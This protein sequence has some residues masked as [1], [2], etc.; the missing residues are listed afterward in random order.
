MITPSRRGFLLECLAATGLAGRPQ[1]AQRP[2]VIVVMTDDQGYGDLSCHGNP[3]LKTPNIDA[4]HKDSVRL[5]NYHVSPTC[6]PTRSAL[7]TG[8]YTNA[9]GAWHTI[10]G[11]S[12]LRPDET[13][14]ADCFRA[15]GYRTGI[16]GKWHLG[17][18]Y[19][20]RPQERGFDEVLVHGG[21]GVSQTPDH[22]GND[23]FDDTYLHNGKL[24]KYRGFCT[25]VW[26]ENAMRFMSAEKQRGKPFFCYLPT[27]APHG[28]MWAP[29]EY[30]ARFR[31]VPGLREP[32][33]FGMIANIDDNFGRMMR[34]L[35]SRSLADNT[36]VIFT[37]DN[38]TASGA[39]VHNAGMRGQK[40]SPYEGG[41]RVPFFV[42][43]PQGGLSGG[44]DVPQLAAHVDVLPTLMDL[45]GLKR[46]GKK[47]LHGRSLQPLLRG[48]SQRW[49]DRA[50]T[51]DSQRMENLV[52]WRQAAVM[53][54]QWRLVSPGPG[55]EPK[56]ELYD[57]Q[58][59]PRQ[60]KDIAGQHPDVVL[61]LQGEYEKWWTEVSQRAGEVVRIVLGNDAENPVRLTAHDWHGADVEKV[62]HQSGIRRGPEAVG[63]WEVLVE[64]EGDYRFELRRW[65]KE[66][67]LAIRASYQDAEP[68]REK[69]PG[70]AIGAVQAKLRIGGV[71]ASVEV[72]AG[73]KAAV[74]A[75]RLKAGPAKLETWLL[76][77][78]GAAR[79]A[80]FVYVERQASRNKGRI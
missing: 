25:D 38:G 65:P 51:V 70:Q 21:G 55:G 66:V 36:I 76:D 9:T 74:L 64:R 68:N 29:D 34:F 77:G 46:T 52:K 50:I 67:D 40:G 20:C 43:W 54:Q 26:F 14:L 49:S 75:V 61:R 24:E 8:R 71:E 79:G 15:G 10:M 7:L 12:L 5:T 18:N 4:L 48:E 11:R 47:Q 78:K 33:F 80:Y 37:T 31:D 16:F 60:Q 13:T 3:V 22:F 57:I 39:A 42:R 56:L 41:H 2:N 44:R 62:W 27:N 45:C 59:D 28:P 53:T 1:S 32:G 30:S 72:R 19:P 23:Y 58:K 17:D 6:A 73:D 69:T 63:H 35:E